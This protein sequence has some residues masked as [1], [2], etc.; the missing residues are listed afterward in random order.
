MLDKALGALTE[1][2]DSLEH[3]LDHISFIRVQRNK[4]IVSDDACKA[5]VRHFSRDGYRMRNED[6]QF[7]GFG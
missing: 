2:N 5:L 7:R 1:A 4:R 6:F 3:V